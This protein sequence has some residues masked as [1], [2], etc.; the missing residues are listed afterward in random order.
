ML[1]FF[2]AR[3]PIDEGEL[4]W[5]LAS[6]KWLT[7]EFGNVGDTPL[8]LPTPDFFAPAPG[9]ASP[10]DWFDAVRSL[11][12]MNDWPCTLEAGERD[13]P[14]AAGNAHL[15]YHDG[16]PAPAGTFAQRGDESG[17]RQIVITYN[18]D[19]E[20]DPAALIGTFAH[21]LAHYLMYSATTAPPGGWDMHE[22][23]TD[24]CAVYMGF[25]IFLANGARDFRQYQSGGEMGWSSSV[26]GY[27]SEGALVTA[28]AIFQLLAGRDPMAASPYLKDYLRTDLRRASKALARVAPDMAAAVAG[29]DL[30]SFVRE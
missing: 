15:L 14:K 8:V 18:P 30:D 21:E 27:L 19:L 7:A 20:D 23:H 9:R 5:Q 6:F 17:A 1:S 2:R 26:R 11:A 25:G 3:L 4:E 13:R 16:P 24:L 10:Q 28:L 12:G 22:L 29:A